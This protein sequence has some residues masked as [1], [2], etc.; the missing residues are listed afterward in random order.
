MADEG[1][2]LT[3]QRSGHSLS[4][5]KYPRQGRTLALV[6]PLALASLL[7]LLLIGGLAGCATTPAEQEAI[8]KAWAARDAERAAECWRNGVGFAAGGCVG[9]F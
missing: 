7:G 5:E 4:P 1:G 9:P 2:A 6:R 8:R 3:I